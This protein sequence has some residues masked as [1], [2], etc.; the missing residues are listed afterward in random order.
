[1]ILLHEEED[2]QKIK[3]THL[4][5]P[6]SHIPY[7]TVAFSAATGSQ[8]KWQTKILSSVIFYIWPPVQVNV[9][10]F[11]MLNNVIPQ[12]SIIITLNN[13][14]PL[15]VQTDYP[16]INFQLILCLEIILGIQFITWKIFGR[17]SY[18]IIYS[19]TVDSRRQC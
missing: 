14:Q 3:R 15:K 1:M 13:L 8:A 5:E 18:C 6:E 7:K 4:L 9:F 10:L 2:N 12:S 16:H 19:V 11:L 17:Y